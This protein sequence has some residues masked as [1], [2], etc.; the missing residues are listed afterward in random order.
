MFHGMKLSVSPLET[1]CFM[2]WNKV[3]HFDKIVHGYGCAG[4]RI[5]LRWLTDT[6][7]L[8]HGYYCVGSRILLRRVTDITASASA[9]VSV[10]LLRR[11]HQLTETS[12][13]ANRTT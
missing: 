5:R 4:S 2:A 13:L 1:N 11:L 8:A 9:D 6:A 7:A 10:G 12:E 3:F